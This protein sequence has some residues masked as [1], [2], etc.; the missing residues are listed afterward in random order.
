[1]P[2]SAPNFASVLSPVA[3]GGELGMGR[4][5]ENRLYDHSSSLQDSRAGTSG[6]SPATALPYIRELRGL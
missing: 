2:S 4:H 1:M 3:Q 6:C 5:E